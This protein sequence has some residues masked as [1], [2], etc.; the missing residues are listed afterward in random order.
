MA[1]VT[2]AQP[3][4]QEHLTRVAVLGTLAEFHREPIPYDLRSLVRLVETLRPDL[5]CLDMTVEQWRH[6][7][8]D[9]LPP[10]YRDALL[11]LAHQTDIVVVPIAGDRLPA[12][13][14]AQGWRGMLIALLRRLLASIQR[15][16]PGPAALNEGNLHH[17]ADSLY[18]MIA[19]LGGP[20]AVRAWQAHTNELV[21]QVLEVARRDPGRRILVV[22]NLRHCHHIR[23]ALARHPEIRVVPHGLL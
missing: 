14:S 9:D 5:L 1:R 8:F 13:P 23:P 16:A 18:S 19:W 3:V 11:P 7:Q 6:E 4:V 10:E 2:S 20:Q 15:S 21:R 22:V 12:E 17:V